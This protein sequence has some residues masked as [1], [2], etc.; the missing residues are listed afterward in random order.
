V[1]DGGLN[2]ASP[3]SV[4]EHESEKPVKNL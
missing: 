1:E 2:E 4:N 3:R